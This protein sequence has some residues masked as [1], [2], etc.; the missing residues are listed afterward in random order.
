MRRI[1]NQSR[2][3]PICFALLPLLCGG[4]PGAGTASA[5]DLTPRQKELF[6]IHVRPTLVWHCITCHGETRQE[7]GRQRCFAPTHPPSATSTGARGA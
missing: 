7:G 2:S 3:L 1:M 5:G 4:F 6:E